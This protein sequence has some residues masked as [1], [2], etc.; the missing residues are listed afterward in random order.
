MWNLD[1]QLRQ[2]SFPLPDDE[3]YSQSMELLVRDLDFI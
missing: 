2:Y 1:M 3:G